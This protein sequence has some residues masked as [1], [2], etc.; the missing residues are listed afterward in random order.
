[1]GAGLFA[2]REM[3][4]GPARRRSTSREGVLGATSASI[5]AGK[6]LT[7]SAYTGKAWSKRFLHQ[8]LPSDAKDCTAILVELVLAVVVY[9]ATDRGVRKLLLSC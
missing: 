7:V 5:F 9:A 6:G 2:A 8:S 1:M 3:N 4:H